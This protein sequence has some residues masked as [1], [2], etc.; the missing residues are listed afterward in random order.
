[1]LIFP[2]IFL[3]FTHYRCMSHRERSSKSILQSKRLTISTDRRAVRTAPF[4][5]YTIKMA[6]NNE[7]NQK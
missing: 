3:S 1:M 7:Q 2:F 6:K 5:H 4:S